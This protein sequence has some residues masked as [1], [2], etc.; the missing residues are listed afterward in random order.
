MKKKLGSSRRG[1]FVIQGKRAGA[2]A[3]LVVYLCTCLD[4]GIIF[5]SSTGRWRFHSP[6]YKALILW[7]VSATQGLFESLKES[8]MCVHNRLLRHCCGQFSDKYS[9]TVS[10]FNNVEIWTL[11]WVSESYPSFIRPSRQH[12]FDTVTCTAQ[13]E[14]CYP[15]HHQTHYLSLLC[16][17]VRNYSAFLERDA[18]THRFPVWNAS[19]KQ[20][21]RRIRQV[22]LRGWTSV[23]HFFERIL[24]L[25]VISKSGC[26]LVKHIDKDGHHIH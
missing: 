21:K 19:E 26:V 2:W 17:V 24:W 9:E 16:D 8:K 1:I 18:F 25:L 22:L 4:A 11:Q 23:E 14:L 3:P 5:V 12:C 15:R 10:H 6:S 20:L 7:S 13:Q